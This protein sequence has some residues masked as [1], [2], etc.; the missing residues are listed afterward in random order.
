MREAGIDEDVR[1]PILGHKMPTS[2]TATPTIQTSC[3]LMLSIS[4]QVGNLAY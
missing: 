3:F 2:H 4:L 1:K